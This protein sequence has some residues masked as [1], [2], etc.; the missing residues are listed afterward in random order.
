MLHF[1]CSNGYWIIQDMGALL[2]FLFGFSSVKRTGHQSQCSHSRWSMYVIKKSPLVWIQDPLK[3]SYLSAGLGAAGERE[4][5]IHRWMDKQSEPLNLRLNCWKTL[6][7]FH[8][9][10][11]AERRNLTDAN[12]LCVPKYRTAILSAFFHELDSAQLQ[13][14]PAQFCE[15]TQPTSQAS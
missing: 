11:M 7:T 12:D 9:L 2:C 13:G 14:D 5:L 15:P 8:L 6:W 1:I 10:L 4:A 3:T